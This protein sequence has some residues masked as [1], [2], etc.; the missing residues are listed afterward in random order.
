M[1]WI[2]IFFCF[3]I[4]N[5]A[6]Q[7]SRRDLPDSDAFIQKVLENLQS[8]GLLQSRYTF[9]L[10][11]SKFERDE[12]GELQEV[13]VNE[14]EV[15]PSLDDELTY[16]RHVSKN[17]HKLSPEELDKQDR[18]QDKKLKDLA[19][20][21]DKEGIDAQTY[22]LRIE[23]LERLK[24]ERIL[25]EL[26]LL[27]DISIKGRETIDG[28]NAILLEFRPRPDYRTR[29]KEANFLSKISGRAWFCEED[30]QLMKGEMEFIENISF[31]WGFYARLHKGTKVTLRRQF[32]NNE[33]WMPAE[34]RFTGTA[35]V[36]LLKKI[37]FDTTNEFSNYRKF[38]VETSYKFQNED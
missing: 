38:S 19:K 6:V 20:K 13:E 36:F 15:F 31:G 30:H 23:E 9:D 32:V 33:I 34:V 17:G 3:F 5:P 8:D 1:K 4:H 37:T 29:S 12:N 2:L 28:R 10:K 7:E 21:L 11:Q 27:Y 26:P 35:R 25:K 18:K 22:R 14:Y 24:E 16:Q